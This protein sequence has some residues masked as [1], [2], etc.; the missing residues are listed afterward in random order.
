[1]AG[2]LPPLPDYTLQPLDPLVPGIPDKYLTLALPVIAYWA[3][4]M[5]FHIIDTCD[6][7]PQYR[8]HTPVELV[9]R[10]HVSRFDVFRDVVLQHI[11]QTVFGVG[12]A[13]FD[14]EPTVGKEDYDIAWWAQRIR[15]AEKAIP[16]ALGSIGFNAPA[17]ATDLA[18]TRPMLAGALAG[19]S[20][21]WLTQD[22]SL[23]GQLV[24]APA[25]ASWEL[26]FAKF[27]YWF[28]IPAL[29]FIVAVLLVDTWQYFWHRAMH[30]NKWLYSEFGLHPG[31]VPC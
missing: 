5:F 11:I 4:S 29:Q 16:Y 15:L 6:L 10:N 26:S 31:H 20:Y 25:F 9:Q 3:V 21:P 7:F 14:P 8:L 24:T 12:L 19:G 23:G 18:E 30:V 27:V 1:M 22:I 28:A 17:F 2:G 13:W